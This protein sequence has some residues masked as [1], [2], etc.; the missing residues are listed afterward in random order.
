MKPAKLDTHPAG[1]D[2]VALARSKRNDYKFDPNEE[3]RSTH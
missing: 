2:L 1:E 3:N